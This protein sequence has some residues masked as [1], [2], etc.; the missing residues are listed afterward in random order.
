[1]GVYMQGTS[2]VMSKEYLL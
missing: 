1:M 2:I